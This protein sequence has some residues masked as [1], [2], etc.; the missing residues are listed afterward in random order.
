MYGF[1]FEMAKNQLNGIPVSPGDY[2]IRFSFNDGTYGYS[3]YAFMKVISFGE[4]IMNSIQMTDGVALQEY[5]FK[6]V[7]NEIFSL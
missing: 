4:N 2:S 5:S 6:L 1:Y 3:H 7:E